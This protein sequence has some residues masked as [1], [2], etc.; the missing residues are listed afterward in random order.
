MIALDSYLD[1][2]PTQDRIG[3]LVSRPN[4][5]KDTRIDD[6]HVSPI[7]FER[8]SA[9]VEL[10]MQ[11]DSDGQYYLLPKRNDVIRLSAYS[12][13][14]RQL[15]G[16][17]CVEDGISL[18]MKLLQGKIDLVDFCQENFTT[19]PADLED[20]YAYPLSDFETQIYNVAYPK[21]EELRGQ[22]KVDFKKYHQKLGMYKQLNVYDDDAL[23]SDIL[24]LT[25]LPFNLLAKFAD[26]SRLFGLVRKSYQ[27]VVEDKKDEALD[28]V[29]AITAG[30][31]TPY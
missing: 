1:D 21:H 7:Y 16:R 6:T 5:L 19:L 13:F 27:A 28:I 3:F 15:L 12:P 30:Y 17:G 4:C 20:Y 29:A 14:E 25:S 8:R 2:H 22:L 9:G 10:F 11:F 31:F 18:L 26:H 23:V 24:I